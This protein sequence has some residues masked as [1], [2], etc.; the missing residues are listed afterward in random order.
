MSRISFSALAEI[1]D[2]R[3]GGSRGERKVQENPAYV[4]VVNPCWNGKPI[5]RRKDAEHYVLQGRAEWL[6]SH[7]GAT[8]QIRLLN[9]P[10]NR[11]TR[12]DSAQEYNR[13][14]AVLIRQPEEL[15]HIPVLMPEIA[16]TRRTGHPRRHFVD[17][18]GPVTGFSG[19]P[20]PKR[21]D[22]P[23]TWAPSS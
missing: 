17:K 22:A 13:A 19:K 23:I 5:M 3:G 6:V 12:A 2:A 20:T 9:H 1:Q 7:K 21:R 18:S 10:S 11:A 8:D 14:A 16:L 15:S 4:R